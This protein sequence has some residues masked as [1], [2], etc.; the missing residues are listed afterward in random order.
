MHLQRFLSILYSYPFFFLSDT[1]DDDPSSLSVALQPLL[2]L[3]FLLL[4]SFEWNEIK[5]CFSLLE[6]YLLLPLNLDSFL[7][8][9]YLFYSKIN[10]VLLY[11]QS[12]QS[13]PESEFEEFKTMFH[14]FFHSLC[15]HFSTT[16]LPSS[17]QC[18]LYQIIRYSPMM[19]PH[20]LHP[21]CPPLC[22]SIQK[23]E[24]S[25]PHYPSISD[26]QNYV[27]CF[28]SPSLPLLLYKTQFD[29]CVSLPPKT[30]LITY[31]YFL[32]NII[33]YT[34]NIVKNK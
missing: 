17:L 33:F 27:C 7:K 4:S 14:S 28:L 20:A 10:K 24:T 29:Q 2:E 34:G 15:L 21:L 9:I 11:L 26:P 23:P 31:T 32:N 19:S 5:L 18:S 25:L 13:P 8:T 3:P 30:F 6:T 12:N 1:L 16:P 22:L